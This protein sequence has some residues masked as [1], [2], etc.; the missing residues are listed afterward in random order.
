MSLQRAELEVE[1]HRHR[2]GDDNGQAGREADAAVVPHLPRRTRTRSV[3]HI[4]M[5]RLRRRPRCA[6]GLPALALAVTQACTGCQPVRPGCCVTSAHRM[7]LVSASNCCRYSRGSPSVARRRSRKR[8]VGIAGRDLAQ[9]QPRRL[10]RVLLRVARL[11]LSIGRERG[12]EPALQKQCM[13]EI[14]MAKGQAWGELN[15]LP[16]RGLRLRQTAELAPDDADV[17]QGLGVGRVAARARA[18]RRPA[19]RP[20]DPVRRAWRRGSPRPAQNPAAGRRPPGT[21]RRPAPCRRAAARACRVRSGPPPTAAPG[22]SPRR[23]RAPR[24]R[25]RSPPCR[26]WPSPPGR[27]GV[28]PAAR[29]STHSARRSAASVTRNARGKKCC[30][31]VVLGCWG[32]DEQ[33]PRAAGVGR[34]RG[35]PFR[36][37]VG[38][39][40]RDQLRAAGL[41]IDERLVKRVGA[42]DDRAV[43]QFGAR[44]DSGT[45]TPPETARRSRGRRR[46]RPATTRST[47]PPR[48]ASR[49]SRCGAWG[50]RQLSHGPDGRRHHR[51]TN[52]KR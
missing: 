6:S 14:V 9:R 26:R 24:R 4:V 40:R 49:R 48:W 29:A 39:L 31:A 5:V 37:E 17:V 13:P 7:A 52:D 25:G 3:A 21:P 36:L 10:H 20:A 51:M 32:A 19:P 45:A 43:G 38:L 16:E 11:A 18:R 8:A 33:E 50:T 15:H 12:L 44:A 30:G 41:L 2:D 47:P 27:R 1:Q 35:R 42:N 23:G 34:Q 46:A 28:R 22:R